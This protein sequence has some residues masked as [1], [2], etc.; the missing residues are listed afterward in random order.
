MVEADP[1]ELEYAATICKSFGRRGFAHNADHFAP[2]YQR[3][4]QL[5]VPASLPP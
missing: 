4:V 2:D 5:G 1:V 3:V